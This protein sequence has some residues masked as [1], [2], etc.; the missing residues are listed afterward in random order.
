[1]VNASVQWLMAQKPLPGRLPCGFCGRT[2]RDSSTLTV[3]LD[4]AHANWVD[5]I[6]ERLGLTSPKYYP[7]EEYRRALAEAFVGRAESASQ[8]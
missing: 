6:L 7:I 4:A 8:S 2:Y 1:M 5:V 3:H